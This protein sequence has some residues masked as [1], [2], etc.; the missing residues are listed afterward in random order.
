MIW[1]SA[2]SVEKFKDLG[3]E[4]NSAKE[5]LPKI[6]M[7]NIFRLYKSFWANFTEMLKFLLLRKLRN[8]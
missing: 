8:W 3:Q 4:I 5:K 2:K 1:V 6:C 7:K